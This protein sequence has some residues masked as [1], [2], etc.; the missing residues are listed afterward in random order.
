MAWMGMFG[1]PGRLRNDLLQNE[2]VSLTAWIL[3]MVPVVDSES[4]GGGSEGIPQDSRR[5]ITPA[6]NGYHEIRLEGVEDFVGGG[7]A[8]FVH[9]VQSLVA[10]VAAYATGSHKYLV[11]S[12]IDLLRHF[13]GCAGIIAER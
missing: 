3:C 6:A 7:L 4:E 11:V 12:D 13:A 10:L 1:W 9:L 2:C 8:Q 5:H